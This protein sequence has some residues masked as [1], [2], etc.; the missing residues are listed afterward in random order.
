[1][2]T[3]A[4][5]CDEHKALVELTIRLRSREYA[6]R[7]FYASPDL[8]KWL[9]ND[10]PGLQ[11]IDGSDAHPREQFFIL[12]RHFVTGKPMIRNRMFRHL[13]P[14]ER[15][16]FELKTADL[17]IFGWFLSR[18]RFVAVAADS[19]ERIKR[20]DLYAGYIGVVERFRDSLDLDEPKCLW[21][22]SDTDV[23]S[24]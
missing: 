12:L 1:M 8:F 24:G 6:E 19:V 7:S 13:R 11:Q 18:D 10:L 16:V 14:L 20:H 23:V 17:R 4:H 21:G 2:A 3:L 5:L 15:D 9:K 22:A